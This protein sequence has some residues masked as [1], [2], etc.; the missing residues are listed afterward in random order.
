MYTLSETKV[1]GIFNV[2]AS[3]ID[4]VDKLLFVDADLGFEKDWIVKLLEH[5]KP[6]VGGTYPTKSFP[7]RV[8]IN[9][10]KEHQKFL[11]KAPSIYKSDLKVLK[12]FCEGGLL[13]IIHLPTGFMMIDWSVLNTLS[14][15]V[16]TYDTRSEVQYNFFPVVVNKE[17]D[18]LE[19]EDWAF[20]SLCR[21]IGI[22]VYVD[23][24]I[25]CKHVGAFVYDM[26]L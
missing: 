15:V 2:S 26:N 10:F 20:C 8:N 21:D 22:K 23:L 6:L 18:T 5:D 17:F 24:S 3:S 14:K 12:N 16:D 4:K 25:M 19:S 9:V 13:D 1:E 11:E 7:P